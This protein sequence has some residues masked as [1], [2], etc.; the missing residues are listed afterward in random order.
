MAEI[1][2]IE[3]PKQQV[4]KEFVPGDRS[5]ALSTGLLVVRANNYGRSLAKLEE[6]FQ[7]MVADA[8]TFE[9]PIE[10][11]REDVD[12]TRYGGDRYAKTF[13]LEVTIP[14]GHVIPDEYT[15]VDHPK[16]AL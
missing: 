11:G 8:L 1:E 13:G 2:K 15:R 14:E 12:V 5:V 7:I 3:H 6:L 16:L 9:P 4:I 10:L